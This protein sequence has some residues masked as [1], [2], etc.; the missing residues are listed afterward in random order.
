MIVV[1]RRA[2]VE[3]VPAPP[4]APVAL[5]PRDLKPENVSRGWVNLGGEVDGLFARYGAVDLER[6][7]GT[8]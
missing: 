8:R 6:R 7:R 3:S 1:V 2:K 5:V 4:I